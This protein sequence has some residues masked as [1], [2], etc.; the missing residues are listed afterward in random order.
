M[1][2][3]STSSS[4]T[5]ASCFDIYAVESSA[6]PS[7]PRQAAPYANRAKHPPAQQRGQVVP[8]QG[9]RE[10]L[11]EEHQG[12]T[13]AA[14]AD[15]ATA[16][17]LR[18]PFSSVSSTQS[19]NL[20]DPHLPNGPSPSLGNTKMVHHDSSHSSHDDD[21]EG[22]TADAETQSASVRNSLSVLPT[23]SNVSSLIAVAASFS[24]NS[25]RA[26]NVPRCVASPPTRPTLSVTLVSKPRTAATARETGY[27]ETVLSA[28]VHDPPAASFTASA[29]A[30]TASEQTG[31][32]TSP[33]PPPQP[34]SS[35]PPRTLHKGPTTYTSVGTYKSLPVLPPQVFRSA[36]G[37][38][39]AA[40]G[41]LFVSVS[42]GPSA[43][44]AVSTP[45][46]GPPSPS[47]VAATTAAA[48][49]VAAP[50]ATL[51]TAPSPTNMQARLAYSMGGS[52][53]RNSVNVPMHPNL[54][55]EEEDEN[56]NSDVVDDGCLS[57]DQWL[58][59]SQST[60]NA[61]N[62]TMRS[63]TATSRSSSHDRGPVEDGAATAAAYQ[64]PPTWSL[65]RPHHVAEPHVGKNG[66]SAYS[67][68]IGPQAPQTDQLN[69]NMHSGGGAAAVHAPPPIAMYVPTSIM[70]ATT[71]ATENVSTPTNA[72]RGV[73][74]SRDHSLAHSLRSPLRS[75]LSAPAHGS[76]GR[77]G[78]TLLSRR[79]S[80]GSL[81]LATHD[82]YNAAIISPAAVVVPRGASSSSVLS[83]SAFP[84]SPTA[85]PST[86]THTE[87]TNT[88]TVPTAGGNAPMSTT[89]ADT[90]MVASSDGICV[91][92]APTPSQSGRSR[93]NRSSKNTYNNPS[94]VFPYYE[95]NN[96]VGGGTSTTTTRPMMELPPA[97]SP[98]Q[99]QLSRALS[100]PATQ[101]CS[102]RSRS[103]KADFA[104][105]FSYSSQP[106]A[107]LTS[108][109]QAF[110]QQ[111]QLQLQ[112]Q[113]QQPAAFF[114]V[115]ATHPPPPRRRN[116]QE[117]LAGFFSEAPIELGDQ[118]HLV[119]DRNGVPYQGETTS[120]PGGGGGNT[121]TSQ[122]RRGGLPLFPSQPPSAPPPPPLPPAAY[123]PIPSLDTFYCR[124]EP[125]Y[126]EHVP[127]D[128]YAP[129]PP[130]PP[131]PPSHPQQGQQ[132]QPIAGTN[133]ATSM[134]HHRPSAQAATAES[135]AGSSNYNREGDY[136]QQ[137][138]G[139]AYA[140]P[141]G[142]AFQQQYGGPVSA[143]PPEN[144]TLTPPP[145]SQRGSYTRVIGD[146]FGSSPYA[147]EGDSR[148]V[149]TAYGS[150]AQLHPVGNGVDARAT[151]GARSGGGGEGSHRSPR[152]YPGHNDNNHS[153]YANNASASARPLG[154][155]YDYGLT[156]ALPGADGEADVLQQTNAAC[157]T[158]PLPRSAGAEKA[159][160]STGD[161]H[162]RNPRHSRH[163]AHDSNVGQPAGVFHPPPQRSQQ[164]ARG[165]KAPAPDTYG[166]PPFFFPPVQRPPL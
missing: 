73:V 18:S 32:A 166:T 44:S 31:V 71:T 146:L 76:A 162:P 111:Q 124:T 27:A 112:R 157:F 140:F 142:T 84:T 22:V 121:N 21:A 2:E 144:G 165:V 141:G 83:L 9:E 72:G 145:P 75:P 135:T 30:A 43:S 160:V 92:D 116:A 46:L 14:A 91:Q 19:Q 143:M 58:M 106:S 148:N 85:P 81:R 11:L 55:S 3:P 20:V 59:L 129:Y 151:R 42:N 87:H 8:G 33:A 65:V 107:T 66:G 154:D 132:R 98:Y 96:Y 89:A 134:L 61:C 131:P 128:G 158:A 109:T 136:I 115:E 78:G 123:A 57:S 117:A 56:M 95:E 35:Q 105:S 101:I 1:H 161:S 63:N 149:Q 138:S 108:P 38:A 34:P 28:D 13:A 5:A 26:V 4:S 10:F 50:L 93:M 48:G 137:R 82:P 125:P 119:L 139:S 127:M 164:P 7:L 12:E 110:S 47:A 100:S 156:P 49:S 70:A 51:L 103:G 88:H 120:T 90:M 52:R 68:V 118:T 159:Q 99:Q 79:S 80:F 113:Q 24:S 64:P 114:P 74:R 77:G 104:L 62:N 94:E 67:P 155:A 163:N 122:N 45:L 41:A 133:P 15:E 102:S 40:G 150:I 16:P 152:Y 60:S 153:C 29:T 86:A 6:P 36:S 23:S 25:I 69:S 39:P 97:P 37:T 147:T 130:P 53:K 17:E 126:G 54:G